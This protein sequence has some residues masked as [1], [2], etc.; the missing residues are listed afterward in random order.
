MQCFSRFRGLFKYQILRIINSI[1]VYSV[2]ISWFGDY[3]SSGDFPE[4]S[5]Y[6]I[7]TKLVEVRSC[8]FPK[9]VTWE[10]QTFVGQHRMGSQNPIEAFWKNWGATDFRSACLTYRWVYEYE[11]VNLHNMSTIR[12]FGGSTPF[13][14][15][16]SVVLGRTH[17]FQPAGRHQWQPP[18]NVVRLSWSRT[19]A[20]PW[21]WP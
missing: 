6:M 2:R 20:S 7:F 3:A 10:H 21:L 15:N 8:R 4:L 5:T 11:Y 1:W 12:V 19:S 17:N 9:T 13:P 16:S 18:Q 14:I